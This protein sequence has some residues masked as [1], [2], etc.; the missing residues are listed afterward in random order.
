M[1]ES[2]CAHGT[3]HQ[4]GFL[5][6]QTHFLLGLGA[7]QGHLFVEHGDGVGISLLTFQ[8]ILFFA[9]HLFQ[10]IL[11]PEFVVVSFFIMGERRR[12]GG[13][14]VGIGERKGGRTNSR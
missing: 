5:S 3:N 6:L 10:A 2:C 1:S 13:G 11:L 8:G 14:V 12:G 9:L 4:Q 7:E